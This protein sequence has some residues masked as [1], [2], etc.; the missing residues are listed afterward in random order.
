M[1]DNMSNST[2]FIFDVTQF[3]IYRSAL[4]SAMNDIKFL[5][6]KEPSGLIKFINLRHANEIVIS[7]EDITIYFDDYYYVITPDGVYKKYYIKF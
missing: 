4:E 1:G 6:V 5:G 7:T 3:N 2:T